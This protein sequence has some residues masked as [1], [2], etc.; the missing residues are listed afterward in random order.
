MSLYSNLMKLVE[1]NEAF[2]F[3]DYIVNGCVYRVFNYLLAS[4]TDFC[5][6]DALE[7]RGITFYIP[8]GDLEPTCVARPFKKFFNYKENPFTM[9][10]RLEDV[11]QSFIKEDGSIIMSYYN[12]DTGDF[13][14]KSKQDFFSDQSKMATA[15]LED[16]LEAKAQIEKLTREGWTVILELVSPANRIVLEYPRTELRVLGTRHVVTGVVD[17][18]MFDNPLYNVPMVQG[19]LWRASG[20]F[21][22]TEEQI[23]AQEGLEGYV[24]YWPDGLMA[25]VK[26]DWYKSLH[27][28]KDSVNATRHLVEAIIDER[29]DDVKAMFATDEFTMNRI[30]AMEDKVLPKFNNIVKT[31]NTFCELNKALDVKSFAIKGQQEL[32]NLFHLAMAGHK[33]K[34]I[35]FKE[36][37]KKWQKELFDIKEVEVKNE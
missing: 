36:F 3:K 11:E 33:G 5:A 8:G 34:S 15:W 16:N 2:Y 23:Y 7:A 28:L 9:D 19:R 13:G 31:V 18:L 25:K 21:P 17:T 1:G 32:G 35:E 6:E 27:H 29:I 10:R 22:Y 4:Y 37:A 20:K 24:V 12:P 30:K 14:V 26:T